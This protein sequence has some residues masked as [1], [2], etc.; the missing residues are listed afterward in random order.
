[1]PASQ[2]ISAVLWGLGV[3]ITT[4][5]VIY[6]VIAGSWFRKPVGEALPDA[7]ATPEPVAP[8]HEYPEGIEEAHGKV[9]MINKLIMVSFVLWAIGYVVLFVQRGFT[10]S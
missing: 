8:V 7:D 10:F 9:P 4:I 1:M 5:V 2:Q 6:V 3:G